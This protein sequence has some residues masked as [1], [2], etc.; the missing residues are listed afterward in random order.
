[1]E[2][3]GYKKLVVYQKAK[4]LVL[5]TYQ[6]CQSLPKDESFTL[7]PQIERAAVSILLN[8]VE[9]Y[10]KSYRKE[11]CRFVDISIGSANELEVLFE[12]TKDLSYLKEK[13]I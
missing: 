13:N 7:I 4:E 11:Y 12:L 10:S 1:M 2:E 8:I 9:G 5:L 3:K 6:V